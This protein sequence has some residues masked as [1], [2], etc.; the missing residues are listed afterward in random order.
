MGGGN[1]RSASTAAHEDPYATLNDRFLSFERDHDLFELT[2]A[3]GIPVWERVRFRTHR[4]VVETKNLHGQAHT[5]PGPAPLRRLGNVVST[6]V[7]HNPLRADGDVLFWGHRRRKPRGGEW[8]DIYCNALIEALDAD[9]A[10]LERPHVDRHLAPA[11]TDDVRYLD[12]MQYL[13]YGLPRVGVVDSGF[14][15]GDRSRLTEVEALLGERL[16]VADPVEMR[17]AVPDRGRSRPARTPR[18]RR[19]RRR[20]RRSQ[21]P[22]PP[23]TDIR[24]P[25]DGR[26]D[27]ARSEQAV[28]TPECRRWSRA[29][30]PAPLP[31]GCRGGTPSGRRR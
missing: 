13:A 31:A 15:A 6:V 24:G 19:P 22:T 26:A 5:E 20:Q 14:S 30:V 2:V 4:A 29:V 10:Y 8:W 18:Q 16:D 17:G 11:R 25:I 7:G 3:D 28:R 21:R 1:R 23:R 12:P 27:D 9:T